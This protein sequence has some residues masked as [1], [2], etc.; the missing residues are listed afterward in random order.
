MN[1]KEKYKFNTEGYPKEM[2]CWDNNEEDADARL[3]LGKDTRTD[4]KYPYITIDEY[5]DS[6]NCKHVKNIPSSGPR[7]IED[8]LVEGDVIVNSKGEKRLILGV[9]GKAIFTSYRGNH[10]QAYEIFY[11]LSELISNDYTLFQEENHQQIVELTI[12][13]ISDGKGKGIDANLIRIKE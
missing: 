5:G 2:L 4:T 11:T 1:T 12:Q 3:V 6:V 7:K 10:D 13:D 8:G 9:C